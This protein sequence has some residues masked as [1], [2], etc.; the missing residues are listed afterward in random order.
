MGAIVNGIA[1]AI[2]SL[3]G[4]VIHKYI[5]DNLQDT[6]FKA[7]GVGVIIIGLNGIVSNMITVNDG[8]LSSNGELLLILSL[9][10]GAI[11]GE[12]IDIDKALNNFGKL[13]EQKINVS[14]FAKG[15]INASL[16]FCIGAM[17]IIGSLNDGLLHDP[18][19][20]FVKSLIDGFTS[21]ILAATMGIGVAFSG[22]PVFLYEGLITVCAGWLSPFITS[23][24]LSEVCMVGY[25]LVAIIGINFLW[26]DKLKTANL[27]PSLLVPIV[28][29]L[30]LMIL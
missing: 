7:L 25:T 9:A 27:L 5:K 14:G 1:I 28:Y 16:I 3:L 6:L 15:F 12:M 26:P 17:A 4:M 24:L 22:V 20:L 10:L 29:H 23:Q 21:I 8:T 11:I 18:S 13:I 30:I 2:S 19:V